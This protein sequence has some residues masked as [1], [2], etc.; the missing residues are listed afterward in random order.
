LKRRYRSYSFLAALDGDKRSVLPPG[1]DPRYPLDRRIGG[2]QSWSGHRTEEK[3]F[4][5]AEDR[6]PVVIVVIMIQFSFFIIVFW[7]CEMSKTGKY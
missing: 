2:P 6:T 1:R 7:N 5:S 3:S 4:A